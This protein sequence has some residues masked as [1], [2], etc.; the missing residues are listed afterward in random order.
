MRAGRALLGWSQEYLAERA[1]VQRLVVQRYESGTQI[2]LDQNL[3]ALTGALRDAGIEKIVRE[4]GASGVVM[5][6]PGPTRTAWAD[7]GKDVEAPGFLAD[8]A[9]RMFLRTLGRLLRS[10]GTTTA[11]LPTL[12]MLE[13]DGPLLQR[14]LARHS[15]IGQ[16]AMAAVLSRLE[17]ED[18]IVRRK[19]GSDGRAALVQLTA[20]GRDAVAQA[21][22]AIER[23]NER[24]L[25]GFSPRER[26]EL[27]RLL[28]RMNANLDDN[29]EHQR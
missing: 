20:K 8:R 14:D 7:D 29:E 5:R 21:L 28:Q 10:V 12:L 23:A 2:P 24:A 19:H 25:A 22:P 11:Q 27:V 13:R 16:P 3:E 6:K 15:P 18:L 9:A 26:A 1:R 4:D 17:E